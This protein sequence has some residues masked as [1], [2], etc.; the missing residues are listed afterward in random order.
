MGGR[1]REGAAARESDSRDED[2]GKKMD[3]REII[4]GKERLSVFFSLGDK[5][6]SVN[7]AS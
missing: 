7:L 1:L 2:E 6:E 4:D 3:V 5:D